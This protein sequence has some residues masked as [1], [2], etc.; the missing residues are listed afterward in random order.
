MRKK[1]KDKGS[2][3]SSG[4]GGRGGPEHPHAKTI[5]EAYSTVVLEASELGAAGAK[6]KEAMLKEA[7]SLA[8]SW[9]KI[10]HWDRR[11]SQSRGLSQP[12]KLSDKSGNIGRQGEGAQVHCRGVVVRRDV[13]CRE[14]LAQ[15]L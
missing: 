7:A 8:S 10:P 4:G 3:R 13:G 14:T 1:N 15:T 5:R 12:P 11:R 6:S 9:T 2:G